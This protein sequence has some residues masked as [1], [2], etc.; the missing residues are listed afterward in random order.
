MKDYDENKGPSY[1]I[2]WDMN[3]LYGQKMPK[4]LPVT[5]QFNEYFI[6]KL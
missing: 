2:Y 6:K 4:K 5:T 3:N 1:L